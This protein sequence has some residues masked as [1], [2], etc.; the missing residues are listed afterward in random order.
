MP[1]LLEDLVLNRVPYTPNPSLRA[2]DAADEL[3]V[4]YIEGLELNKS[5]RFLIINDQ[6]G[7]LSCALSA[8][9]LQVWTDSMTSQ[10]AITENCQ[11]NQKSLPDF[12]P[13]TAFPSGTFDLV[14][15][16]V[17][18]TMSLLQDQLNCLK[19]VL[20]PD[21]RI[22]S[23]AMLKQLH[24]NVFKTFEK[25]I[26]KTNASLA[27]KKARLI[28]SM[29]DRQI[30]P[31]KERQFNEFYCEKFSKPIVSGPNV[32]SASKLDEGARLMLNTMDAI[33]K[34]KNV[35]D[36]GCGNGILGLAYQQRYSASLINFVDESYMAV[37]S[38][39]KNYRAIFAEDMFDENNFT[40]SNGLRAGANTDLVLCNPP[41]HQANTIGDH[42]AWLMFKQSY[43]A[44][45]AKGE[46]WVVGN[47]HLK[48]HIKLKKIFATVNLVNS[49][50]KFLILQCIK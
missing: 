48:Y 18:K 45:A 47:R 1:H 39:R 44:L 17:P 15:I 12:I 33:P 49:N 31:P 50:A 43:A 14:L 9:A 21:S 38:A 32:Y 24:A 37:E 28:F 23:G 46:L 25:N 11:T 10:Q 35:V 20:S 22:I 4:D 34:V 26:G 27:K 16:K 41:F 13:S 8:Y 7:A 5:S 42:I 36:L 6:F 29:P 30:L 19:R 2:W 3:L 40:V